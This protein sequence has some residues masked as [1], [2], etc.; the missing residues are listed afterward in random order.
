M[1]KISKALSSFLLLLFVAVAVSAQTSAPDKIEIFDMVWNTINKKYYDSHFNGVDWSKMREVYQ[2]RVEA[3]KSDDEFYRLV[4]R[5]VSE[6]GD[7]HTSFRTPRE[8]EA[9]KRNVTISVGVRLGEAEGKAVIFGVEPDTEAA[10]AGLRAGMIVNKIDGRETTEILAE[11]RPAI[12]SSSANAVNRKAFA[13]LLSGAENTSVLLSLSEPNDSAARE[14]M[15]VRRAK[16]SP[17]EAETLFSSRRLPSD[18]GYIRFDEFDFKVLKTFKKSLTELKDTKGLII[19]LRFNSGGY[20]YAMSEMAALFFSEKVSFGK[21]IT[22]TGKIPK[23]LGISLVPKETFVGDEDTERYAA[24]VVILT[25]NYSASAAEHFAAG[26]QESGR[27]T[28]VGG[29][30]CGC[31]LGIMG[32]TKIKG[33]ELYVSQFDFVTALGKRIEQVGVLPDV[34]VV[35]TVADAQAG[36]TKAI[37]EAENLLISNQK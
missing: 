25:S 33:G 36:F 13:Q 26:M 19:D 2:P 28:I 27:A 20:H 15:L 35:P 3:A 30:S 4:K 21:T 32:K 24:P 34:T 1:K 6:L 7:I 16:N 23:I 22:R 14:V 9:G 12:K 10:R 11:K 5:M 29:R 17:K 37:N 31:M 18:V 8:V